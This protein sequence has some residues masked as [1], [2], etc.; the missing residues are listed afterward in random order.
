VKRNRVGSFIALAAFGAFGIAGAVADEMTVAPAAFITAPVSSRQWTGVYFGA[1][2]GYAWSSSVANYNP[3][4]AAAQAGTCGGVGKGKCIPQADYMT[5]GPLAGGQIGY[6]WQINAMW[7]AGVETDYQWANLTGRGISPFHL[8]NVGSTTTISNAVVNPTINSFGTLRLR[9][10]VIPANPVLLYGTGGLAFGQVNENLTILSPAPG[11]LSTGGF[12]YVCVVGN[13]ACFAGASSKTLVGWT[14]GGGGEVALTT[15]LT[16][17]TELLYVDLGVPKVSTVAQ[18]AAA[19]T[20]P[21]SFSA[22]LSPAGFL[23]LR[24][25]LNFRF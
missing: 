10:G 2:G 12:S 9:M 15:N 5:R 18:T 14:L 24:G 11:S 19:G 8:G 23:V 1:N 20:A 4:D 21:S 6:N 16:L 22:A 13:P 17:K 25:G 3:N 7:L